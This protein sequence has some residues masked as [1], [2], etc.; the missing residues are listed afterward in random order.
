MS[1]LPFAGLPLQCSYSRGPPIPAEYTSMLLNVHAIRG[2]ASA[3]TAEHQRRRP[4]TAGDRAGKLRQFI[5][6]L[7]ERF[8]HL[9]EPFLHLVAWHGRKIKPKPRPYHCPRETQTRVAVIHSLN[10]F[11]P[12]QTAIYL[13]RQTQ[14]GDIPWT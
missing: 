1:R 2:S 8:R 13:E 10:G 3:P 12:H 6:A 11:R 7:V 9:C 5:G 4:R 14:F